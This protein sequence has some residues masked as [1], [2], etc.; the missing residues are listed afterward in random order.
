VK[1]RRRPTASRNEIARAIRAEPA[2]RNRHAGSFFG[3]QIAGALLDTGL[4]V[5]HPV[6]SAYTDDLDS[7]CP[8]GVWSVSD[9]RFDTPSEIVLICTSY[10]RV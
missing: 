6:P 4:A 1:G 10:T 8:A 2:R 9:P 3:P 7:S 5:C